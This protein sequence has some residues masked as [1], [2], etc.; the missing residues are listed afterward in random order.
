MV[1]KGFFQTVVLILL[2]TAVNGQEIQ[3]LHRLD[4]GRSKIIRLDRAV[5]VR[6]FGG[7]K[8]EGITVI[9]DSNNLVIEGKSIPVNDI[10]MISGFVIRNPREKAL[11]VGLIIGAG[12]VFPAAL[13]YFLGGFAW[14]MPYGIFIGS[15][16]LVFDLMLAYAGSNLIGIFPRRFSTMNWQIIPEAHPPPLPLPTP[17]D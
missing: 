1:L 8:I 11:G 5:M 15:T 17:S 16:V 10:M 7:V 3:L 9:G 14:G 4:P 2:C 12:V 13:Y 6:T